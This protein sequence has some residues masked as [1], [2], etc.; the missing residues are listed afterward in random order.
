MESDGVEWIVG[1]ISSG[2]QKTGCSKGF[3][4][5]SSTDDYPRGVEEGGLKPLRSIVFSGF[6]LNPE[7]WKTLIEAVDWHSVENVSFQTSNFDK[8]QFELMV[9]LIP[10]F[11]EGA[12][13]PKL[14]RLD[15]RRTSFLRT[16]RKD[17]KELEAELYQLISPKIPWIQVLED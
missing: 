14:E 9:D 8:E 1:V 12:S 7:L 17:S 11:K 13:T 10:K 4:T 5:S 6:N 2:P 3:K 15:L 16:L